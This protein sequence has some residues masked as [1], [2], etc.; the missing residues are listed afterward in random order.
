M[1]DTYV[2]RVP[3]LQ[4]GLEDAAAALALPLSTLEQ[5]RAKGEGP[6]FYRVG[7]RVFTTV[8]LIREWQASQI[9]TA[10][11]GDAA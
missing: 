1:N 8:D 9:E 7:R 6:L 4:L 5:L 2:E 3:R 11:K 10:R